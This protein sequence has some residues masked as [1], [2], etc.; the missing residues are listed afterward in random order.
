MDWLRALEAKDVISAILSFVALIVS[1]FAFNLS[2]RATVLG[3]KPVLVFEY[4]GNR[5]WIL[6]NVG[7]GPALNIIVAQKQP[8]GAWF[9][10][11]R[12]P[13]LAKDAEFIPKWGSSPESVT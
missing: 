5:G 10:P 9:N 6:R 12:V 3:R 1:V 11:V 2:R 4:D 7:S 8:S 13:P